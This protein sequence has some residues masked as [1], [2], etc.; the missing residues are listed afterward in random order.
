MREGLSMRVEMVLE[1]PL[2][3]R[4]MFLVAR[5]R[6]GN[7]AMAGVDFFGETPLEDERVDE[8]LA[9]GITLR[10]RL[11]RQLLEKHFEE[12]A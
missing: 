12:R 7:V 8:P 5:D 4:G 10:L 11:A 3:K 9:K 2:D 6:Y 1:G